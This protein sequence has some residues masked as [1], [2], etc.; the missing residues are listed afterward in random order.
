MGKQWVGFQ[1]AAKP[2]PGHTVV[3][4]V[5]FIV[6]SPADLLALATTRDG[7]ARW[8]A[9]SA[10][11]SNRLGGTIDFSDAA[12]DFGGSFTRLDPPRHVV[13]VTERHGEIAI[14]LDVRVRPVAVEVRLTRVVATGEDETAIRAAMRDVAEGFREACA[15][16]R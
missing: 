3:E 8:L 10:A 11:F 16:G 9:P 12:G 4:A 2:L 13:L 6:D 5:S 1:A 15:D 7:L 14:D